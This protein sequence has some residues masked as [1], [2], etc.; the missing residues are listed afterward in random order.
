MTQKNLNDTEQKA[1]DHAN[2]GIRL[3]T[4]AKHVEALE[5]WKLAY[6]LVD[7]G[8]DVDEDLTQWVRSG[9]GAALYD[10]AAYETAIE[11]SEKTLQWSEAQKSILSP[12]T[13]ARAHLALGRPEA[14]T[15]FLRSIHSRIGVEFFAQFEANHNDAIQAAISGK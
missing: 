3:G 2:D 1:F 4:E 7:R 15:P 5:Q 6:E 11:V 14:A 10:A 13:I 12:L 9:Y 8:N